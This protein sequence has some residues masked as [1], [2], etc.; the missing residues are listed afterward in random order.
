MSDRPGSGE[1][2]ATPQWGAPPQWG[3][4]PPS[5]APGYSAP[6]GYGTPPGYGSPPAPG[7]PTGYGAPGGYGTP[8][9]PAGPPPS[10]GS[11]WLPRPG[12]VPLRP[13]SLGEMYDGAF[14]A[15]RS[16]PRTM[17]GISAVVMLVVA[18]IGVLPQF[19]L[20]LQLADFQELTTRAEQT[21][22]FGAE[23][24][25]PLLGGLGGLM[26]SS[27]V[28]ALAT[29]ALTALLVLA[30]S[31]AVLGRRMAPQALWRRVR[32]RLWR[33]IGLALLTM[34]V[35]VGLLVVMALLVGGVFAAG[36]AIGDTAGAVAGGIALL[37][38]IPV[39]LAVFLFVWIRISLAGPALRAGGP[40]AD[41]G[42]APVVAPGEGVVVAAV[43]HP[44]PDLDHG[45]DRRRDRQRAV[46][47]GGWPARRPAR[48]R[49]RHGL[50]RGGPVR[51]RRDHHRHGVH[52][53]LGS[54]DVAALHRPADARRGH[55]TWSW[56][57]PP[58]QASR[59]GRAERVGWSPTRCEPGREEARRWAADEL[60][61]REYQEAQPG[62]VLRAL[63]W[64]LDR[65]AQALDAVPEVPSPNVAL[66]LGVLLALVLAAI[67][68]AV[69][70]SGGPGGHAMPGRSSPS[71]AREHPARPPSTGT[72]RSP[73][74]PPQD[75]EQA[76][77][78]W[79]RAIAREL[80]ERTVL[81]P[82]PGRT[83]GEVAREAVTA[84]PTRPGP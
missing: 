84:L 61:R 20:L 69:W 65:I 44:D 25:A 9:E 15:I 32:P 70:R 11:A 45:V 41:A 66:G 47:P 67:G 17:L 64:V 46:Q 14:Q 24:F 52:P 48:R 58:A 82:R 37:V 76:V 53:L 13:L 4:P 28:K 29:T 35:G 7:T 34:L 1:W 63:N 16:N 56:S 81:T 71:S 10:G 50:R 42:A 49:R 43:R 21:G 39:L 79:F 77:T 60:A 68:Y 51:G 55:W 62:L 72:R 83:A 38:G 18:L 12:I 31:E 80:E 40:A 78:E 3:P 27:A 23:M 59:T 8:P 33:V 54:R 26:V 19:Y 2:G 6:P 22:E 75:W 57:G 30:V 73:P 74:R 36:V 5:G